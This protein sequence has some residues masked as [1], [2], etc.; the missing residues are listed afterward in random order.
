MDKFDWYFERVVTEADLDTAFDNVEDAL[1][2]YA[3][4]LGVTGLVVGGAVTPGAGLTVN[5]ATGAVYDQL[6]QRT[7]WTGPVNVDMSLDESLASTAV[8][9]PGNE[10]K[11]A[12]FVEFVRTPS[13]PNIDGNGNT[14]DFVLSEDYVFNVVQGA[15]AAIGAATPPALR[16]DQILIADIRIQFGDTS[17]ASNDIDQLARTEYAFRL[18]SSAPLRTAK[19]ALEHLDALIDGLNGSQVEFTPAASS[20]ADTTGLAATNVQTAID[21]VVDTLGGASGALKVGFDPTGSTLVSTDVETALKEVAT[22]AGLTPTASQIANVPA[23]NIAATNV[24]DALNEL[25]TEKGG[26]ALA[27]VWT[28]PQTF[29]SGT[30]N[31]YLEML[32]GPVG[33]SGNNARFAVWRA[34]AGSNGA[35]GYLVC[36]ATSTT[37]GVWSQDDTGEPS[38]GIEISHN[39]LVFGRV[40]AGSSISSWSAT[41]VKR[42]AIGS[43]GD[44]YAASFSNIDITTGTVVSKSV[45][46][47]LTTGS[48]DADWSYNQPSFDADTNDPAWIASADNAVLTFSLN[49][50]IPNGSTITQIVLVGS[51]SGGVL[52]GADR[53]GA[54]LIHYAGGTRT[55]VKAATYADSD[56]SP[57]TITLS[58]ISHVV[59]SETRELFLNVRSV[60]G[61]IVEFGAIDVITVTYTDNVL[62]NQ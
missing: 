40:G 41:N 35:F 56:G 34:A 26:L 23:G 55:T 49:R 59:N 36:N 12:L 6:G 31:D 3:T 2:R 10:K 19:E 32:N 38:A 8:G 20:W 28:V 53:I 61:G 16:N 39:G 37:G 7:S 29:R 9:S 47:P 57:A 11:L 62:S 30:T 54:E 5:V 15:E 52:A 13:D 58:S 1:D 43:G 33:A 60:N 48:G 42:F 45:R 18:D 25:D 27:N 4:D 24:Q 14:V 51:G 21:E 17:F 46:I 44:T 50:L 22:L